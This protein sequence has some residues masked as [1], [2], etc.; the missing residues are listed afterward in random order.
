MFLIY[1][2]YSMIDS[3]STKTMPYNNGADAHM[4][5]LN[6]RQMSPRDEQPQPETSNKTLE[7]DMVV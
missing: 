4:I 2:V 1:L 6:T 3:Q 7:E 5:E